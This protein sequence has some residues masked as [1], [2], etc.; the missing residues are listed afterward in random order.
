MLV[1]LLSG[2]AALAAAV[3]VREPAPA[4]AIDANYPGGNIVVERIE[5]DTVYL[6]PDLRDTEGWWFYWSFRV[7]RVGDIAASKR[8]PEVRAPQ[9]PS[10][11][12]G[13]AGDPEP[14]LTF[15]F[16]GPNPI[17]VRGP[18]VST[19]G[20]RTWARVGTGL[21]ADTVVDALLHDAAKHLLFCGGSNGVY[22]IA[23]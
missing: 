11:G 4:I 12:G 6:R 22:S 13:A 8:Q 17:G 21:P 3:P 23:Y 19:D 10:K 9:T 2:G 16:S 7:S 18:A 20:G 1:T 14:T 5:G 15:R